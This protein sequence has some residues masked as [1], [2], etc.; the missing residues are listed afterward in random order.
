MLLRFFGGLA[1]VVVGYF[2][3]AKREW[4]LNNFGRIEFFET[5]LSSFGGSRLAYSLVGLIAIFFGFVVAFGLW[6]N[7]LG[8][9]LEPIMRH[10]LDY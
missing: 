4:L 2:I 5:K 1:I 6:G 7:F 10:Q 3:V 9:A 8:W